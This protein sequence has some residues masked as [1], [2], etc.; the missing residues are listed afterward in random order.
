MRTARER[1]TAKLAQA[2]DETIQRRALAQ[3]E[4]ER[5]Q[6]LKERRGSVNTTMSSKISHQAHN[7]HILISA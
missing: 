3:T 4:R 1:A 7:T 6:G 2:R 5:S